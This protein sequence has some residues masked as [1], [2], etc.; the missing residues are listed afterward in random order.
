MRRRIK[1]K[2]IKQDANDSRDLVDSKKNHEKIKSVSYFSLYRFA[3][4]R[5]VLFIILSTVTTFLAGLATPFAIT[6]VANMFHTMIAYELSRHNKTNDD[7]KFLEDMHKFGINYSLVGVVMFIGGYIGTA[8][9]N[10][11][12]INQIFKIRQEY[13]RAALNQD[14][15]YFDQHQ[16]GDFASKMS[17]DVLK[18]EQGVGDKLSAFVYNL[19]IALSCIIMAISKGWKLALLCL[20]TTPIT[21]ILVGVSGTFAHRLYKREAVQ[22]GLASAVAEEVLSSIRTV[23]AFNGQQKEI[24]RYG[25]PLAEARKISIKKELFTGLS[26]G[27]LF[28]SI[29]CSYALSFYFGIYLIVHEP[30]KYNA[31]VMFSVFFGI[32]TGMTNFG[33]VGAMMSSFGSA[34]GAAAQIFHLVDNKPTI[35]PYLHLGLTPENIEGNVEFKNVTFHYPSRPDI[36][37]LKGVSLSV[38]RGQSVAFVGQS[39]CGKSTIIQLISRYYDVIGG[40]VLVDGHDVRELSVRWLRAQVG[41]VGQEPVL[42][43]TSVR[44]NIRYGREDASDADIEA[45]ARQA[46]AHQFILKL[47]KGYETLVG[48]R[49]ASL[50][51]GQKQRIAIARALVRN[52]SIL[53][54]DEATSAL[55]TASEAKVQSALD[56]GSKGRTTFIVAHRLSTIKNV[57]LI[58]VMKSGVVV[59]IGTHNELIEKK[60]AYYDLVLLQEPLLI[61]KGPTAEKSMILNQDEHREEASSSDIP[62][63]PPEDTEKAP[64]LSFWKILALNAPE[65]KSVVLGSI[66]AFFMGF[67]TP[68]IVVVFG[69]LF[70]SMSN[71]N[72][73]V[74]MK[75]VT[76]VAITCVG[77]GLI[78][79][80]TSFIETLAFGSAGAHL[81][82]RLRLRMFGHLLRQQLEFFDRRSNSTGALCAKLS[83]EA[84][85]V[86]G[87]TGQRVG[88]LLQGIAS[89]GLALI[90]AMVYQWQVGLVALAFLPVI[91]L[92]VY[93]QSVTT[94]KANMRSAKTVE[95]SS[96]KAAGEISF[97]EVEF[98]YPTRP[99]VQV[100]KGLNLQVESFKTIAF[101]GQSGCGKSTVIQL[102]ERYYDPD[103]GF[104]A[105]DGTA[106]TQLLLSEVRASYGLVSQE[107]VLFDLTIGEN[108]AYGD[109][110]RAV[111]R[112]EVIDA[113]KQANIHSFV[114]TLPEGYD[115]NIG[116]KGTQ[117]SGGQKQRVAIARALT[118]KPKI[119]L[120]DEATSALDTESEKVVQEA[121]DAA[122]AGRTCVMIA[123]RLSTVRD[124][125]LICVVHNG[126][127]AEHGTHQQL[128]DLKKLYYNMHTDIK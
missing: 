6:L 58:Y 61:V 78:M 51:G 94:A 35:N 34:R 4:K 45:A 32:M 63:L 67:S 26:M 8:L 73:E 56:Q 30:D 76:R 20:V 104:V 62:M 108:I 46:N 84:S 52:P 81:T 55:D 83:A 105:L 64:S 36:M 102:L 23:Y 101:V 106:L 48:E 89:V 11:A 57:D 66:A 99:G 18:L 95:N 74:M 13:L 7:A 59:E 28:F 77:I 121:L 122:K 98:S 82:E 96:K 27:F 3:T 16:T 49:G 114:V 97:K 91:A 70:G 24:E 33:A 111:S 109:N 40:S 120:L 69:K 10:V 92:V 110:S 53:L 38:K 113:A 9:I 118:R 127:V 68:I 93:Y 31:D 39:G 54:L 65:W 112:E 22:T 88:T 124:A 128:M 25:R 75:E 87:A 115:T 100:L 42:F 21:F 60:G 85:H 15:A 117:L 119:L 47:P 103:A 1:D 50:S 14:L 5:D 37:I 90:L 116:K 125:D 44:E 41:L 17:D 2:S 19:T 29:F 123:H 71:P 72:H 86:Q 126:R 80:F 43:N 12:A 107:P 79:G